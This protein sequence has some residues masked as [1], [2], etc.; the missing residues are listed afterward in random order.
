MIAVQYFLFRVPIHQ[1][2]GMLKQDTSAR[3]VL[4]RRFADRCD[5]DVHSVQMMLMAR[6]MLRRVLSSVSVRTSHVSRFW[7][8][9][10][11]SDQKYEAQKFR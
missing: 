7:L 3:K 5:T 11:V 8:G 9:V 6:K 4:E 10:R 1:Q 2:E